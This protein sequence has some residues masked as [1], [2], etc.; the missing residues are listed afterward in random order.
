MLA[1]VSAF[2]SGGL[3]P[4]WP[5]VF[6]LSVS[7]LASVAVGGGIIL[8]RPKY[9]AAVHRVAFWLIVGGVIFEAICTI[10]LFVFDEGISA[11]QQSKIIALETKLAPRTLSEAEVVEVAGTLKQFG[12]QEFTIASYGGEPAMLA[13]RLR[14]VFEIA[15]WKWFN[16]E[17]QLMPLPGTVGIQIWAYSDSSREAARQLIKALDDK[18]IEAA[19]LPPGPGPTT[20]PDN[21]KIEIIVGSKF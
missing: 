19:L 5:H 10:F 4:F 3:E 12:G 18:F 20:D 14:N 9:S 15:G 1:Y 2:I 17:Y 8:E 11:S 16:P 13:G 7:V 21:K 6:L